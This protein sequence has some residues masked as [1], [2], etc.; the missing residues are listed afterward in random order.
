MSFF[1]LFI[2]VKNLDGEEKVN[3]VSGFVY[4]CSISRFY[5]VLIRGCVWC[6]DV[7]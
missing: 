5:Y 1:S 7:V 2:F 3:N 6:V 4:N